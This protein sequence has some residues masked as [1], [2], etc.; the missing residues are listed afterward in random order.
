MVDSRR[1]VRR[2]RDWCPRYT[3]LDRSHRDRRTR[4]RV[5]PRSSTTMAA[6]RT[7]RPAGRD[8]RDPV[9]TD[10]TRKRAAV[11][12]LDRRA[13]AGSLGTPVSPRRPTDSLGARGSPE[14][15]IAQWAPLGFESAPHLSRYSLL[16][17]RAR[18]L[19]VPLPLPLA[20][21]PLP[22]AL[23]LALPLLLLPLPAEALLWAHLQ[24]RARSHVP[25]RPRSR[26]RRSRCR[27]GAR[28]K[29]T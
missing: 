15:T 5:A 21:P 8:N 3:V 17:P 13:V 9:G 6:F 14:H 27:R 10:G 11:G 28:H 24:P 2:C 18:A 16:A 22:L 19:P 1:R 4:T 25:P 23:P 20:L 26:P 12:D 29:R 7:C